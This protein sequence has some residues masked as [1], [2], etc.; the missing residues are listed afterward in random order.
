MKYLLRLTILVAA[1]I[2]VAWWLK[3]IIWLATG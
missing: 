1:V 3:A 2:G